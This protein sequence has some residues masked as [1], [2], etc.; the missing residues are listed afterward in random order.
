[1]LGVQPLN[2]WAND[3]SRATDARVIPLGKHTSLQHV[4]WCVLNWW[5]TG[6]VRREF[7]ELERP[8]GHWEGLPVINRF[9]FLTLLDV[10][11]Y[12]NY[13][14]MIWLGGCNDLVHLLTRSLTCLTTLHAYTGTSS[15]NW[16]WPPE[17]RSSSKRSEQLRGTCLGEWEMPWR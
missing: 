1:V 2:H 15:G 11:Y 9:F 10:F 3:S 7:A 16:S 5:R 13:M 6:G 14:S 17:S 12:L 8:Q 4:I